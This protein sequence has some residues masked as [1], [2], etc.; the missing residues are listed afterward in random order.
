MQTD[1]YS[2]PRFADLISSLLSSGQSS[3]GRV[4]LVPIW[5]KCCGKRTLDDA[6][7]GQHLRD[8]ERRIGILEPF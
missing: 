1:R 5:L 6:P 3:F 4:N 2:V 8:M 7:I